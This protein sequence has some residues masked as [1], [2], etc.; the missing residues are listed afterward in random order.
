ME[1]AKELLSR[2]EHFARSHLENEARHLVGVEL[3]LFVWVVMEPWG[4]WVGGEELVP[5]VMIILG[6]G[7][8]FLV[9]MMQHRPQQ[10][11]SSSWH[12]LASHSQRMWQNSSRKT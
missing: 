12:F 11:S 10:T 4:K 9:V 1:V 3:E 5:W 6:Q 7:V 2:P 8:Q